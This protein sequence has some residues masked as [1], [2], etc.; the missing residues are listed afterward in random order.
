VPG[1]GESPPGAL[2]RG[3]ASD[4]LRYWQSLMRHQEALEDRPSARRR[5]STD[6]AS[7][8]PTPA[9]NVE[10]PV[11]G[12]RYV[13]LDAMGRESFVVSRR[14]HVDLELDAEGRAFF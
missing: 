1:G 8:E 12:Q 14:G 7:D 3:E 13:K 4:V 10:Q 5:R 6:G 11:A 2:S 9:A